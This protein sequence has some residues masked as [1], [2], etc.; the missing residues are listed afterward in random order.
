MKPVVLDEDGLLLRPWQR[1]DGEAVY[2]ACQDRDIQ[3]WT[4]VPSPYLPDH[5][6]GFV[7]EVGPRA[8]DAGTGAPFAVCD[9]ATGRLLG[10]CG[11][12]SIDA[13]VR[14]G[15][16]GYWTAPWARGQAVAVR[17]SRAVARWAFEALGLRRVMWQAEVGNHASRLVALRVGFRVDGLVRLP[18]PGTPDAWIGSLTLADLVVAAERDPLPAAPGSLAARRAAIFGRDQ[19]VLFAT[20][21]GSDISLRRPEAGDI[22]ALVAA[23]RDPD[24]AA[25]TTVPSPY[26]RSDAEYVVGAHPAGRWA[27]GD[28]AVSAITDPA[29]GYAGSMELR[30][31]P[32]D[33]AVADVGFLVAPEARGRGYATAVLA[34][35]SA[36]G[37][38][39]LGLTRIEWR[40][41]VGNHASRRVAE[42]AGFIIEGTQRAGC[43]QRGGRRDAW[44]GAV[45]ATDL[46][47][48]A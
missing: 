40:A 4:R 12:V 44:F 18:D 29:G 7:T 2:R 42:K 16:I 43:A 37:F 9:A 46:G 15:Q 17:A 23:C 38:A 19:P 5:A 6:T 10:S 45:L 33:P 30:L 34:A 1:D 31:S 48:P 36:W 13:T 20:A 11:L 41:N 35:L 25:W 22:D 27:R 14:S 47:G 39:A 32:G 28:G 3:R 8:W 26:Q 24:T 21:G